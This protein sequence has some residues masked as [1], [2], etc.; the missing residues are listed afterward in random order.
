MQQDGEDD[1]VNRNGGPLLVV[2]FNDPNSRRYLPLSS[3]RDK[4]M[5]L[6]RYRHVLSHQAPRWQAEQ[7][8]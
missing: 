6:E 3:G 2:S 1:G 7:G 4:A 8:A 5:G